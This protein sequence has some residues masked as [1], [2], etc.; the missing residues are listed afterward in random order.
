MALP[1][2]PDL[3]K[4]PWNTMRIFAEASHKEEAEAA[5]FIKA[6]VAKTAGPKG[7]DEFLRDEPVALK[8]IKSRPDLNGA[9]G[10]IGKGGV[11]AEGRLLV[12]LQGQ[13]QKGH[14]IKV[15]VHPSRLEPILGS[16]ANQA[17]LGKMRMMREALSG[18]ERWPRPIAATEAG[19]VS[20]VSAHTAT[21]SSIASSKK[22]G[23]AASA[24]A[25]ARNPAELARRINNA[26]T[27]FPSVLPRLDTPPC[28]Q[29]ESL[30]AK[31][32]AS[33]SGPQI[34]PTGAWKLATRGKPTRGWGG[35]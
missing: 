1:R 35:Y 18:P 9:I 12:R 6:L 14:G 15:R 8:G 2:P 22:L 19:V 16:A 10:N 24:P 23:G 4:T 7:A 27:L 13:G 30:D 17:L 32:R 28:M 29:I 26:T 25:I 31:L 3:S 20:V 33:A 11:D 21:S 34:G 5:R